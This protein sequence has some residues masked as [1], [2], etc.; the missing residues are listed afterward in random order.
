[1][2]AKD[3]AEEYFAALAFDA[4]L[5]D[6]EREVI[7][8]HHVSE[9]QY[10]SEKRLLTAFAI[11]HTLDQLAAKDPRGLVA[12]VY[13][14]FTALWLKSA[15]QSPSHAQYAESFRTRGTAYEAAL[16]IDGTRAILTALPL[17]FAN[18]VAPNHDAA[19]PLLV[20]LGLVTFVGM[21][22]AVNTL[23]EKHLGRLR[24]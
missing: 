16:D 10:R 9:E 14:E 1:M 21:V 6:V 4:P 17:A 2:T 18:A 20:T 8:D 5:N 13:K 11:D 12:E 19:K 15:L 24:S 23:L 22:K 7:H 3:L